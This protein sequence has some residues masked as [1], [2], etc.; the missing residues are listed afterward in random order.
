MRRDFLSV[1]LQLMAANKK[2]SWTFFDWMQEHHTKLSCETTSFT[3]K[4][5]PRSIGTF[6]LLHHATYT[7]HFS[8]V[9]TRQWNWNSSLTFNRPRSRTYIPARASAYSA[10][11]KDVTS[12]ISALPAEQLHAE[13]VVLIIT[14]LISLQIYYEF[15]IVCKTAQFGICYFEYFR[16]KYAPVV[17]R[18][19]CSMHI[20]L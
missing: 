14:C 2:T 16:F 17:W 20:T 13:T 19:L 15:Y 3:D 12:I 18:V 10:K 11:L 8:H 7:I 1:E 5:A 6:V 9:F 4:W